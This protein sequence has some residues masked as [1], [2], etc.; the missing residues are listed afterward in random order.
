M[1]DY[2]TMGPGLELEMGSRGSGENDRVRAENLIWAMNRNYY[3]DIQADLLENTEIPVL[4]HYRTMVFAGVYWSKDAQ[5]L[6]HY[7]SRKKA[8]THD[9]AIFQEVMML[10]LEEVLLKRI[11]AEFWGIHSVEKTVVKEVVAFYDKLRKRR[12]VYHEIRYTY[13]TDKNGKVPKTNYRVVDL[14]DDIKAFRQMSIKISAEEYIA[15]LEDLLEKHFHFEKIDQMEGKNSAQVE[16]KDKKPPKT[17]ADQGNQQEKKQAEDMEPEQVMAAEFSQYDIGR[18]KEAQEKD[19]AEAPKQVELSFEKNIYHRILESYGKPKIKGKALADLERDL[20]QG[21][22]INSKLHITDKFLEVEGYKKEVL[23][24]T[25]EA[26][27]D[28]F[29]YLTRVYRRNIIKLRDSLLRTITED[30]DFS[31]TKLDNGLLNTSQI[32]RKP[33]L[34]EDTVFYKN[35]RDQRGELIVDILL[36]AS[37]SQMGRQNLVAIQ[38]YIIAEALSMAKIPCR[39]SSFNNLF[40]YTIVK[41]YR[42]FN[43][44]QA[45]N[46]RIFSYSAEG[47][48]RD[49]LAIA[50][51][52]K[53]LADRPEE[54]KV[55]IVLSDGKP[56]DERVTGAGSL[57]SSGTMAYTGDAAIEDTAQKV[58]MLRTKGM[59][60]LGVFT[61]EYEDLVA[62]QKI[63]GRD[64]AYISNI[65]RFSDIVGVYLKKQIRNMLDSQY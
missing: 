11:Q 35:F 22:H 61:G 5:K 16:K 31:Q 49:G 62:E 50:L 41:E 60:V 14:L 37:G 45:Q 63:F 9:A 56:N 7:L 4:T 47:S 57:S 51:L 8:A 13:Y 28:Q 1:E 40:D 25:M 19:Q 48:N 65:E 39:V 12:D 33:V 30:M 32:W 34:G 43:D 42:D 36:D 23:E 38:A 24:K 46:K 10:T 3:L 6:L 17:P 18:E 21:I 29:Q 64:F 20:A 53:L 44:G 55:L 58:R 59:A 26:N 52:G 2:N 54:H 15:R 27:L